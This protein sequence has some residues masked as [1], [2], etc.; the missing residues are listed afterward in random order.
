[1]TSISPK[2]IFKLTNYCVQF[3]L[4]KNYPEIYLTDTQWIDYLVNKNYKF[5]DI[6]VSTNRIIINN[7]FILNQL[8]LM[9]LNYNIY[10]F[11]YILKHINIFIPIHFSLNKL[12]YIDLI[13]FMLYT[14][15]I[16][17]D[18]KIPID[19][20]NMVLIHNQS[21][22]ACLYHLIKHY[23]LLYNKF[24]YDIFNQQ[25]HL[26]KFIIVLLKHYI[27]INYT[28]YCT[29]VYITNNSS[30][31]KKRINELILTLFNKALENNNI[32]DDLLFSYIDL[33]D[34]IK[35]QKILTPYVK[36]IYAYLEKKYLYTNVINNEIILIYKFIQQ[37]RDRL[38]FSEEQKFNI[39][40]F[41]NRVDSHLLLSNL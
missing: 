21:L 31:E 37:L 2:T 24:N 16:S 32:N 30:H 4:H 33:H 39:N 41:L 17:E 26:N 20:I 22:N 15:R 28:H 11:K 9:S 7:D 13:K 23:D 5:P 38:N 25:F 34:K 3:Y 35:Q 12:L 29:N 40:Y 36:H 8:L 19:K 14:Y 6:K 1:M 10:R 27:N 18:D